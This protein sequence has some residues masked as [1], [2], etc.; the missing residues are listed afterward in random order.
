MRVKASIRSLAHSLGRPVPDRALDGLAAF[1][2]L[3]CTW[4][5]R[6]NLTAARTPEALAEVLCADALVLSDPEFVARDVRVV[7][8]GSGAGAPAVPLLV[9]RPDLRATLV[10]PLR[11]RVTFLHTAVGALDLASRA[12]V[13]E[14]RIDPA[15]PSVEG[16]P[17]DVAISRA[18]FAPG[19]WL[20]IGARLARRV[21]VLLAQD[22]PPAAPPGLAVERST[23]YR[24]PSGAP[25]RVAVFSIEA[26]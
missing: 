7:D 23:D 16:G 13:L 3:V 26:P 9:L 2:E 22:A 19:E 25:R 6:M 14:S 1:A 4:N 21:L 17:F 10:E 8:V 18:T 11:K 5:A 20:A 24:L 15:A 12:R